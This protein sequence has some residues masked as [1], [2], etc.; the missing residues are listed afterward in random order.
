MDGD[1]ARWWKMEGE[2]GWKMEKK[3]D[4]S[5]VLEGSDWFGSRSGSEAG[6]ERERQALIVCVFVCSKEKKI[7]A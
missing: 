6:G 3:V 4:E 2:E 1:I 5:G 7:S